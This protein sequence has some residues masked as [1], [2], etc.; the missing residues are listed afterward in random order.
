V[1]PAVASRTWSRN[2]L[3][4]DGIHQAIYEQMKAD[5]SIYIFGEGAHMK[6]HFD[7]PHIERD[8]A[9]RVVTLPI[10]EDGNTN[11]AVGASLVG[12]KPIVDV[13]S[14]DFLYRTMDSICN[15][16]AKLNH[17]SAEIDRPKTLVIRAEFFTGG[18]TTGQRIESL[19][20]H[21]PGLNV[22]LPSTPRDARGLM[23]TSLTNP[24]VTVYFEDRM[25]SDATTKEADKDTGKSENIPLGRAKVRRNGTG[26]TVVAYALALREVESLVDETNVDC[27]LIDPRSL[28]PLDLDTVCESVSRT[29]RLL[30]VE[31]DIPYM[32]IGSEIAASVGERCFSSL[33][34][35]II[36]LGAPRSVIPA[37]MDLHRFMMPSKEAMSAAIEEL[38]K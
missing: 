24:G 3:I 11:F 32:G 12:V 29:G 33:K 6:V 26:L 16:A 36:R 28:Y 13:I 23:K 14:S 7:A 20:T 25:I 34:K 17:V 1:Q 21:I 4:R 37:S 15:T 19:F 31:P 22:V 27:D 38:S 5:P 10:S 35:P 2:H 30:I 9:Q 18:P 8:F